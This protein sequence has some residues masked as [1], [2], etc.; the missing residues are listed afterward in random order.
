MIAKL[1]NIV[2]WD[3]PP[4]KDEEYDDL[5]SDIPEATRKY[6]EHLGK[7]APETQE[8]QDAYEKIKP[9]LKEWG[10]D[11]QTSDECGL[12]ITLDEIKEIA[13]NLPAGKS[14]GPDRIPNEFYSAYAGT[15]APL[16][17]DVFNEARTMQ[18]LPKG[19]QDGI[20]A[21]LYKKAYA[22]IHATTAQ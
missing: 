9:L 6:Y 19:F 14:P 1:K 22:Q 20:V 15:L 18:K 7:A 12:D 8:V 4:D 13:F 5:T 16:L 21:L 17:R 2:N 3:S 10:V 11:K